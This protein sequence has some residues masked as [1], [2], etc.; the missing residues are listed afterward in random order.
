[1]LL[2]HWLCDDSFLSLHTFLTLANGLEIGIT[3]LPSWFNGLGIG[4]IL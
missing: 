1:M 3:V 2:K 4:T